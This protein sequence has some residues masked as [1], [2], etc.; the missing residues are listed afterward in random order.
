M[1][2]RDSEWYFGS[3]IS[4]AEEQTSNYSD[5]TESSIEI[6]LDEGDLYES[7]KENSPVSEF[8]NDYRTQNEYI[9][10]VENSYTKNKQD[11]QDIEFVH[12][13]NKLDETIEFVNGSILQ[14]ETIEFVS[15]SNNKIST[16]ENGDLF[17]S[18]S[19]DCSSNDSSFDDDSSN[20]DIV[21]DLA[22]LQREKERIALL[23][24][25]SASHSKKNNNSSPNGFPVTSDTGNVVSEDSY[26]DIT[27]SGPKCPINSAQRISVH[28]LK[29]EKF[30]ASSRTFAPPSSYINDG[31]A[32]IPDIK[33][34]QLPIEKRKDDIVN[35][36]RGNRVVVLSGSTGCGKSTQVPQY[37]LDDCLQK[38]EP[39]NIICTQPRRI[40]ATSLAHRVASERDTPISGQVGFHIGGKGGYSTATRLRYVTT[41]ILLEMLKMDR[42][43]RSYTHVIM[44]EIHERNVDDDLMMAHLCA[45]MRQNPSL[46]LI[47][48][49]ATM[50]VK[51]FANYFREFETEKDG[52]FTEIPWIDIPTK[53]FPV[54]VFY[55]EDICDTLEVSKTV[56]YKVLS[57]PLKPSMMQDRRELFINWIFHCHINSPD[58]DAFLIFL[59]GISIIAEMEDQLMFLNHL[60]R[61]EKKKSCP[62]ISVIKLH[63]TIT[64][65]EQCLVMIRPKKGYR[66][67]ILATNVA[68]SSITVPDVKI[69]FDSCLRKDIF[70]EKE[71]RC[72]SLNEQ[73]I[74]QD[75]AEQ[76]RGRAGRLRP[77]VVY[78]FVPKKFY[79]GLC[80]ERTPEIRR[81]PLSSLL[82]RCIYANFGDP[83]ELLSHCIDPPEDMAVDYA[84]EDLESTG[85]VIKTHEHFKE[86]GDWIHGDKVSYEYEVTRLGTVLAQLPLDLHSGLLVV[87]GALF[88]A[89]YDT[90]II[91]AILQNRGVIVQPP[92]MEI[93]ISAAMKRFHKNLPDNFPLQGG[94]DLISHLRAYLYW[95]ETTQKDNSFNHKS[96]QAWCQQ[97]FISLYWI[98][99]IQD[100]VI[101]LRESLAYQNICAPPTLEER[102][103][104]R[105][106]RINSPIAR[107]E[108]EDYDLNDAEYIDRAIHILDLSAYENSDER[109]DNDTIDETY[110]RFSK[111]S[112]ARTNVVES[113]HSKISEANPWTNIFDR[114]HKISSRP[115]N[116]QREPNIP[117]ITILLIAAFHQNL[118][119]IISNNNSR[120]FRFCPKKFNRQHTIEFGAQLL[121]PKK[122]LVDTLE[123]EIGAIQNIVHPDTH[124]SDS[125]S[126]YEY[127][128]IEFVKPAIPL[129][130]HSRCRKKPSPPDAVYLAQKFKSV[131]YGIW[132]D[133]GA[134]PTD[135]EPLING[136]T[137]YSEDQKK[138]RFTSIN[139]CP[140]TTTALSAIFHPNQTRVFQSKN[141]LFFPLII[142]PGENHCYAICASKLLTVNYGKSHV[143]EHITCLI[144][145]L[146]AANYVG[147]AILALFANKV[148]IDNGFWNV[149]VNMAR[150]PLF[151]RAPS[152]VDK[153]L[154]NS[155][156][157]F[158]KQA[159]IEKAPNINSSIP[160]STN[161]SNPTTR[162]ELVDIW[163]ECRITSNEAGK[164][165]VRSI[166]M[167]I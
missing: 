14:D 162:K 142:D 157:D 109:L 75:C 101:S 164:L 138:L 144:G 97:Q 160:E 94:S 89:L 165:L 146:N 123:T 107:T 40:A 72:Y 83:R 71:S 38:G 122:V 80:K 78:R 59:P 115:V 118:F 145:P 47:V 85:A 158:M 61:I 92:N 159:L 88:G 150:Y 81:T 149:Y 135:L 3:R 56:R 134:I 41:G 105:R 69:I 126:F 27:S 26:M 113:F 116:L 46:K 23:K 106:N 124:P 51:K 140:E 114:N 76:R 127:C 62:N 5:S 112:N 87:Y 161:K 79:D 154:I 35:I 16:Q 15:S 43:L 104:I 121:P 12:G 86:N 25:E 131:K 166:L 30:K 68:E 96:E 108:Y 31:S 49:S 6:I 117:L 151:S 33:Q 63:S 77:G 57:N 37:I 24:N 10:F 99:E 50:N 21:F 152:E 128:Y 60:H 45:I 132:T 98:R 52:I 55:L 110:N 66:K 65:D 9:T 1:A 147:D 73:W 48:M 7:E 102:D 129:W 130:T 4:A 93:W 155:F 54:D 53:T 125:M 58:D 143:A 119:R 133:N 13:P 11:T 167:I 34:T 91:A 141:S 139:G 36:I 2:E 28:M 64:I 100:M 82:L 44:D 137:V 84:L 95:E 18:D 22:K 103:E 67:I 70:Y 156:R 90:L 42:Y 29:H 17:S 8:D 32:W 19:G 39:V 111:T 20:E 148:T 120:V 163:K 153:S 136:D 74:S